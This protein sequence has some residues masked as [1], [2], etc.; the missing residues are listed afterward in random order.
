M[1]Q[2]MLVAPIQRI[3]NLNHVMNDVRCV[4]YL[5]YTLIAGDSPWQ[6]R[7]G[8]RLKEAAQSGYVSFTS[9]LWKRI[10]PEAF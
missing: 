5:I 3:L 6:C 10:S 7:T 2:K 9:P 1:K 8:K 4:G